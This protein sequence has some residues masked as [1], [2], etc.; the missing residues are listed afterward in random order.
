[1]SKIDIYKL[2]VH[3]WRCAVKF[4][5]VEHVLSVQ[6]WN[7]IAQEIIKATEPHLTN[8]R[9]GREKECTCPFPTFTHKCK[10]NFGGIGTYSRC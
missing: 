5:N 6:D 7:D 9:S 2:G 1:M 4:G 8:H 3:G 10:H